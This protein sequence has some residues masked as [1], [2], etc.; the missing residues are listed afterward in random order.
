MGSASFR[1]TVL[2]FSSGLLA[3]VSFSCALSLSAEIQGR[4][5]VIQRETIR[6]LCLS[7]FFAGYSLKNYI[8][9]CTIINIAFNVKFRES[10]KSSL[11]GIPL[12]P[13]TRSDERE[14]APNLSV[15]SRLLSAL[16]SFLSL[17]LFSEIF[18]S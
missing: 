6:K 12:G 4:Q 2:S 15:H 7:F 18:K 17:F 11:E 9:T 13:I 5:Y 3:T 8:N 14:V 10:P 1:S 16:S